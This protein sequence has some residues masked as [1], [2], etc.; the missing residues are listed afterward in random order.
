MFICVCNVY[1]FAVK[2]VL[3]AVV[4]TAMYERVRSQTM[5]VYK[6]IHDIIAKIDIRLACFLPHSI[7]IY[8]NM[9]Y[10]QYLFLQNVN[11]KCI[12]FESYAVYYNVCI[13]FVEQ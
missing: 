6:R 8:C 9:Y 3:R 10:S 11:I 2:F 13:H 12:L 1:V 5:D 4:C 7:Y